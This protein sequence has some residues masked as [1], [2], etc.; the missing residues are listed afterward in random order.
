MSE[1]FE[2]L[3]SLLGMLFSDEIAV[4]GIPLWTL[5]VGSAI[6]LAVIGFI[7]GSKKG[8]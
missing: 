7:K 1:F 3:Q 4:F 5:L 6:F 8:E 2:A